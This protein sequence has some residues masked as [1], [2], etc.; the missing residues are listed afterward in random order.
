MSAKIQV[1]ISQFSSIIR[2]IA[3]MAKVTPEQ[4]L[5]YEV[6]KIMERALKLTKVAKAGDIRDAYAKKLEGSNKAKKEKYIAY[7]VKKFNIDARNAWQ[8]IVERN[9]TE[10][11]ER[12]A[13]RGISKKSWL[14]IANQFGLTLSG[15]PAY[16]SGAKVKGQSIV[17]SQ[18]AVRKTSAGANVS[19]EGNNSMAAALSP[20]GKGRFA[21]KDAIYGREKLF[22]IGLKKGVFDS[23][24]SICAKYPGL[25]VK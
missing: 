12:L 11:D 19:F 17:A 1:D 15:V 8:K 2:D 10:R 25:I 24:K 9:N 16:V 22:F 7:L 13:R 3:A 23:I 18:G 5:K 6:T 14:D 4:V 21:I 20:G